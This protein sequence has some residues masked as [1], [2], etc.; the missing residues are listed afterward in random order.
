M[1]IE[2]SGMGLFTTNRDWIH[3]QRCERTYEI[4]YVTNGTVNLYEGDNKY[5]LKKGDL[6]L[7]KPHVVHGGFCKSTGDTSFY[8]VHIFADIP[9]EICGLTEHFSSGWLFRELMD[10]DNSP[11][12][13]A[14][15]LRILCEHILLNIRMHKANSKNEKL[16]QDIY[17]WVRINT[18][19]SLT[20]KKT[21]NHFGYNAEHISRIIKRSHGMRLK[22]IIDG[23]LVNK[24]KDYLVN[25]NYSVKETAA[26]CGF[27]ETTA[28]IKFFQYHEKISPTEF[29]NKHTAVHM[30]LK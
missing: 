27:S 26:L 2:F 9:N 13:D 4:I 17:E 28:M 25:T 6:I 11:N 1:E 22:H 20:V 10:Y 19:A 12:R 7:L 21:A 5:E 14:D 30:N 16:V 15:A 18:S 24:I 3:P 8:W 29:R 23:F